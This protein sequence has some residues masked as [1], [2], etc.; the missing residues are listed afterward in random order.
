MKR[1]PKPIS[2]KDITRP[3]ENKR[4][5]WHRYSDRCAAVSAHDFETVYYFAFRQRVEAKVFA[6]RISVRFCKDAV[7]RPVVRFSDGEYCWEV[8]ARGM[9]SRAFNLLLMKDLK[10]NP[11]KRSEISSTD[12]VNAEIRMLAA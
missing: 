5:T 1:S 11:P 4:F 7:I 9:D 10:R 2:S 6:K 12:L 8:K 3:G